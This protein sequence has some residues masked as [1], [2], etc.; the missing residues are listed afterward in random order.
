MTQRDVA[1][2]HSLIADILKQD[3]NTTFTN[4]YLKTLTSCETN[5]AIEVMYAAIK[6]HVFLKQFYC[7]TCMHIYN[8]TCCLSWQIERSHVCT[9]VY[10]TANIKN[11]L[12][13]NNSFRQ[14]VIKSVTTDNKVSIINAENLFDFVCLK[15]QDLLIINI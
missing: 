10:S 7:V 6:R 4:R 8:T 3:A 1:M 13:Y 9:A 11:I 14:T 5:A 12:R 15:Y 2:N